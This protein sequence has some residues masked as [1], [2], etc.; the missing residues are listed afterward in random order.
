MSIKKTVALAGMLVIL[1]AGLALAQTQTKAGE[2][3]MAQNRVE[4]QVQDQTQIRTRT[5]AA[6][7]VM[8]G[9][10]NGDGIC[11]AI[12]DHDND[13]VPNCQDPDW[14]PPKDGTGYK[15]PAG[16]VVSGKQ[17]GA[18]AGFRG[19]RPVG[20]ASF[21]QGQTG[22]GTGVCD[23]TGPKGNLTRKGRG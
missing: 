22:R 14:Q 23:G 6:A 5:S 13:G 3:N 11:D 8:F 21:R 7:R 17:F 1:G 2:T 16:P 15:T 18:S 12:R 9:D 10:E 4:N 20:N 19:A